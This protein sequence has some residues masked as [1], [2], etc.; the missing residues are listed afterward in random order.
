MDMERENNGGFPEPV[1]GEPVR[2]VKCRHDACG[3]STRVRV[4]QALPA[5][6]VRRVVCDGCRQRYECEGVDDGEGAAGGG[7]AGGGA[8]ADSAP[9]G[10]TVPNRENRI[11]KYLSFPLA[12]AAVILVLVLVQRSDEGSQQEP[13]SPTPPAPAAENAGGAG[14]ALG[15]GAEGSGSSQGA[16]LV[17]G[18][19]YTFALPDGWARTE[20][21]GGAT[22][23][24]SARDGG[25]EAT[26]WVQRDPSLDFPQFEAQ[27]LEQLR[28]LSGSGAR[29]VERTT[30]PTAEGTI[31]T[32]A[33]D[34]PP[35]GPAYEV[36][37][38]LAG[39]YRY[40][41]ATTVEPDASREAADG[42]EL[43][44]TSFVPV[45]TGKSD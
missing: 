45:A 23:A 11:W 18:D 44:H 12:A 34:S 27:S 33:A 14:G 21:Q 15:A 8:T 4:P 17:T 16:E 22:F 1:P 30:A 35:D 42:A 39:P 19:S 32:L 20:P 29:V 40:Y 13:A 41:L 7:T 28:Q 6:A 2:L 37:L 36:T 10:G 3:T 26:L 5:R 24:A 38:R 25:A 43:I 31:V 9:A